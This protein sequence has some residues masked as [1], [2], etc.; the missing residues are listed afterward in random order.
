MH[1]PQDTLE[2]VPPAHTPL[3]VAIQPPPGLDLRSLYDTVRT[4]GDF[5]DAH[6]IGHRVVFFLT[7]IA[8]TREQTHPIAAIMQEVLRRRTPELFGADTVNLTDNLSDLAHEL[9]QA[10]I[11]GAHGVRFAP[12][13]LGCYDVS[14]GL[15]AYLNAGGQSAVFRD[16]D[17]TR[18][19]GNSSI[20]LGLFSHR[21]YEPAVQAFEPGA[22]LLLT[23]KGVTESRTDEHTFN[24]TEALSVL[25]NFTGASALQLCQEALKHAE[26][27]RK[28]S[29]LSS[30][31]LPLISSDHI[32][33][34]TA[35]ALIR[36][37]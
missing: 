25:K 23:T 13:F 4:H 22:M 29:W 21:T 28:H 3:P 30:L 5:F 12:T 14:F 10:V 15:L 16:S 26:K 35:V 33:D 2:P 17:G 19:L 9:N 34:L 7:D 20:P 1:T 37:S 24:E 31:H 18:P 32:E 8:G 11:R 6:A 36:T 27:F